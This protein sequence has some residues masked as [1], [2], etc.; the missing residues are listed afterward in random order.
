MRAELKEVLVASFASA[1]VLA[2]LGAASAALG[3][4]VY[5]VGNYPVDAQAKNAVAA[6]KKALAEGQQAAFRSL[7]KRVVPVTAYDRLKR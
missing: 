1:A 4:G 7:L 3:E 2:V 5:T 6:K